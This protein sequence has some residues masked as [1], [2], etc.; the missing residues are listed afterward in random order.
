MIGRTT[1]F[2]VVAIALAAVLV[3]AS[4]EATAA[5]LAAVE[6]AAGPLVS[7]DGNGADLGS[8]PAS[9]ARYATGESVTIR[10]NTG[11]LA[12]FGHSFMNWN[13]A[14]DGSG[15]ILS[16]GDVIGIGESDVTLYATWAI[17]TAR[18]ARSTVSGSPESAFNA[19]ATDASGNLYAAGYQYGAGTVTYGPGVSVTSISS[20]FNALIVKYNSAGVAQWARV[21]DNFSNGVS[22]YNA[23]A[24]DGTGNVYAAGYQSSGT[25]TYG[26]LLTAAGSSGSLSSTGGSF[27]SSASFRNMGAS[28]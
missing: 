10:G 1:L 22:E 19:V 17:G 24:V 7:Y 2:L 18:W 5:L 25:F 12:R 16:E 6:T 27:P 14:A 8:V 23:V 20:V 21:A 15:T 11:D 28:R 13:T 3:L 4:C 9:S 26:F